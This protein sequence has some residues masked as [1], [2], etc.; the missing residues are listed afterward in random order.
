MK[1]AW[2]SHLREL[3]IPLAAYVAVLVGSIKIL[4]NVELGPLKY[5]LVLTPMLPLVLVITAVLRALRRAD[6]LQRQIHLEALAIAF[7]ASAFV[8]FGYG[9]LEGAGLP[10]I[11]WIWVWPVMGTFWLIG[12]QI[13]RL[14]YR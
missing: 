3:G 7:A 10:H 14:R 11:S 4:Q 12:G 6:E 5:L 1:K 9:F 13:A 2:L 8:T